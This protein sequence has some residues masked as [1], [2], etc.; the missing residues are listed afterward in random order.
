MYTGEFVYSVNIY[1]KLQLE[2]QWQAEHT[3]S[4]SSV[5]ILELGNK[6]VEEN[7]IRRTKTDFKKAVSEWCLKEL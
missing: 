4:C 2:I 7:G 5:L 6:S 1:T 3:G